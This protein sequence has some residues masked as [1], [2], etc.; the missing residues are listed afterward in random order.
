MLLLV[1]PALVSSYTSMSIFYLGRQCEHVLPFFLF[2][3]LLD[4]ASLFNSDAL[5]SL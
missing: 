5:F 3:L 2:V 1:P 4:F